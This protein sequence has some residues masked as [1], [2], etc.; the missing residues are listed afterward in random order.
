[1]SNSDDTQNMRESMG[2]SDLEGHIDDWGNLEGH[3]DDWSDIALDYIDGVLLPETSLAVEE[4]L[5]ACP[6]CAGRLETQREVEDLLQEVEFVEPPSDLSDRIR[7]GILFPTRPLPVLSGHAARRSLSW[8]R[9][10]RPWIPVTVAVAAV[11]IGVV[12]IGLIRNQPGYFS[13]VATSTTTAAT[14]FSAEDKGSTP[15]ASGMGALGATSTTAAGSVTSAGPTPTTVASASSVTMVTASTSA[16]G[17]V[18]DK[19]AIVSTLQSTNGPAYLALS[20]AAGAGPVD[21]NAPPPPTTSTST[22]TPSDQAASQQLE[23]KAA[24]ITGLTS[25]EPLP[26]ALS[27][28]GP[29]FAAFLRQKDA[30]ALIDLL[31]SMGMSVTLKLTPPDGMGDTA[32]QILDRRPELPNLA[33]ELTPQPALNRNTWTTSAP[34]PVEQSSGAT[35]T[36]T[37][38]R[39]NYVL[40]VL[41]V[42]P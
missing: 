38:D 35:T 20:G 11:L 36:L 17:S 22:G 23:D 6:S 2:R 33:S 34:A 1:M 25:L 8:G 9:R 18:H 10:L 21:N 26:G 29:T 31:N 28:G 12:A 37:D 13:T 7:E 19:A 4:H 32:A 14:K 42:T 15:S 27:L 40:V 16:R 39:E 3:V 5:K 41:V 24:L 30:G